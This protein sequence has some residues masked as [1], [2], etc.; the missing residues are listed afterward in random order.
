MLLPRPPATTCLSMQ[1]FETYSASLQIQLARHQRSTTV[2]Y[3]LSGWAFNHWPQTPAAL[4]GACLSAAAAAAHL[5]DCLL[6][7]IP[8]HIVKRWLRFEH[9]HN[10]VKTDACLQVVIGSNMCALCHQAAKACVKGG[11]QARIVVAVS[12][13]V[14][15]T[16]MHVPARTGLSTVTANAAQNQ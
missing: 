3:M 1:K 13:K 4:Y 2:H 16:N 7:G 8:H 14:L 11:H 6:M 10:S 5:Q 9:T 15:L 12:P